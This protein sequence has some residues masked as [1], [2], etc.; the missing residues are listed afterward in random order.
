VRRLALLL[1][2]AIV[3]AGCGGDGGTK[4]ATPA[5]VTVAEALAMPGKPLTVHGWI[6]SRGGLYRLCTTRSDA[7]PP[8]CGDPSLVLDGFAGTISATAEDVLEGTVKG[9]TLVVDP[10]SLFEKNTN[11]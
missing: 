1:P 2:L 4:Q 6:A 7:D 8:V 3:L 11:G 9:E 5:G 10:T